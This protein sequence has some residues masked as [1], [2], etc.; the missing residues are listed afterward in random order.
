MKLNTKVTIMIT[1]L[2]S[3]TLMLSGLIVREW[4]LERERESLEVSLMNASILIADS[5]QIRR[6]LLEKNSDIIQPYVKSMTKKLKVVDF[7]TVADM[8]SIRFGHIYDDRLGKKVSG[9]DDDRIVNSGESYTS[10]AMGTLGQSLRAFVPVYYEGEQI[11]YVVTG[12]F[13]SEIL[14]HE[15]ELSY[16]VLVSIALSI[17]IGGYGAGILARMINKSLGNYEAEEIVN[18]FKYQ[19][20]IL[21]SARE[22]ILAIDTNKNITIA[23]QSACEIL[24]YGGSDII[25]KPIERVYPQ[26][27]LVEALE[28]GQEEIGRE[29]VFKGTYILSNIKPIKNGA[30]VVGAMA[31]IL[32]RTELKKLAE[33]VTGVKVVLKALRANSHDFRNKLH[34]LS[35]FLQLG[36]Y[37]RAREFSR[38]IERE[39]ENLRELFS[40]KIMEPTIRELFIGAYN[41]ATEE[42]IKFYLAE[43]SVIDVGCSLNMEDLV[44]VFGNLIENAI[45][46]HAKDTTT[47]EDREVQVYLHCSEEELVIQVIDNGPGMTQTQCEKAIERGYSTKSGSA[48]VG[49]DLVNKITNR[50]KGTLNIDSEVGEGTTVT[51]ILDKLAMKE[52]S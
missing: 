15:K 37:E 25:G 7:I 29:Q 52:H 49:L 19:N 33:E 40:G 26:S 2:I 42:G 31:T 1:L 38:V 14:L 28:T 8:D 23:N 17:L 9:G 12:S 41:R 50:C 36:E 35:G 30:Q 3:M 32:D 27:G 16:I 5:D 34:V 6:G 22:G 44:I 4:G 11:G 46:A 13:Y 45:E 24:K 20:A 51:V 21:S 47:K 39:N 18:L 43:D 48:G 10:I